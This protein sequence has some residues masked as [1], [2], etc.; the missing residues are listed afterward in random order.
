MRTEFC[1]QDNNKS[2]YL[3]PPLLS[4]LSFS[5][6]VRQFA[7]HPPLFHFQALPTPR[8]SCAPA[9][10]RNPP[11]PRPFPA[12]PGSPLAKR[13][14]SPYVAF[15]AERPTFPQPLRRARRRAP[16]RVESPA[17][18]L[19]SH[20]R[21][22]GVPSGSSLPP[23]PLCRAREGPEL[24]TRLACGRENSTTQRSTTSNRKG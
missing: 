15:P 6:S 18:R 12:V 14:E 19:A 2:L 4:L 3:L 1:R 24:L 23:G 21:G 16:G 11:F 22:Q 9:R 10:E 8:T 13:P 20:P 17:G 7:S 5:F